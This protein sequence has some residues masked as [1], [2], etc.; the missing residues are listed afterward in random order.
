MN[1]RMMRMW[2]C[3]LNPSKTRLLSQT[4][5]GHR[6]FWKFENQK[7]MMKTN[8]HQWLGHVLSTDMRGRSALNPTRHA[9]RLSSMFWQK[10]KNWRPD[11]SS[12]QPA[13]N[14]LTGWLLLLLSWAG[15]RTICSDDSTTSKMFSANC[16]H[17]ATK[18]CWLDRPIAWNLTSSSAKR[19]RITT[20]WIETFVSEQSIRHH[21]KLAIVSPES[22][23]KHLSSVNKHLINWLAY[24]IVFAQFSRCFRDHNFSFRGD[25]FVV[26]YFRGAF[27]ANMLCGGVYFRGAFAAHFFWGFFSQTF[28]PSYFPFA[29]I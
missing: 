12:L 18:F 19:S 11:S 25:L 28:A 27:A 4:K 20:S 16:S 1:L 22:T 13:F 29:G 10:K 9:Q 21:W 26:I 24:R 3:A 15:Q 23:D 6:H 17:W 14:F 2:V 7:K 8:G 5:F